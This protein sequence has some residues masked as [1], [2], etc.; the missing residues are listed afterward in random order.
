MSADIATYLSPAHADR[1]GDRLVY[2]MGAS[3]SGKDT[4]LRCLRSTLLPHE[5]VLVAHR[6]ITRPS[7]ADE[8]SVSLSEAEFER[9]V[10]MGCFSLHWASHGLRYGIGVE[11]DAWLASGA[12]VVLNGSRTH[13]AAAHARYP[14]MVAVEVVADAEVLAQRLA[15]RGRETP[16]QIAARLR[17]ASLPLE[18]PAGRTITRLPNNGA[19]EIAARQLLT[20]VRGRMAV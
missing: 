5:P 17:Q 11:I 1:R 19:P 2:L 20:L 7:G 10:L 4:M 9:R 12:A 18:W 15:A 16:A 3:G 6:Y 13:L 8:A 14:G